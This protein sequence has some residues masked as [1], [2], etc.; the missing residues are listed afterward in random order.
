M[1]EPNESKDSIT[2]LLTAA[3]EKS[4]IQTS[5]ATGKETNVEVNI[6][7][8]ARKIKRN[9]IKRTALTKFA[10]NVSAL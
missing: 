9:R 1:F 6:P 3:V 10:V 5:I 8:Q 7:K 2:K 4:T